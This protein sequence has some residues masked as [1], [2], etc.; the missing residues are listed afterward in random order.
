MK[1]KSQ[2]NI[3]IKL[4]E[5]FLEELIFW[6]NTSLYQEKYQESLNYFLLAGLLD[7]KKEISHFMSGVFLKLKSNTKL[8]LIIMIRL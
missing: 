5:T 8:H 2:N 7:P 1:M 3:L 4:N 6:G